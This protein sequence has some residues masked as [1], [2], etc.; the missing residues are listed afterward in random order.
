MLLGVAF[1][2]LGKICLNVR[3]NGKRLF[4]PTVEFSHRFDRFFAQRFAVRARGIRLRRAMRNFGVYDDERG[5]LRIRFGASN[6]LGNRFR[7]LTVGNLLHRPA[8]GFETLTDVFGKREV[9]AA[10]NRNLVAVIEQNQ[11]AEA[12]VSRE[13]SGFRSDAFHEAA[14]AGERVGVVIDNRESFAIELGR[15][16]RFRHRHADRGCDALPQ[17]AGRGFH[18]VRMA[19]LRMS[20]RFAA[21]LTEAL[22]F[23]HRQAVAKEVQQRI[24]QHGSMSRGKH[25]AVSARPVRVLRVVLHLLPKRKRHR[26]GTDRKTRMSA[27]RLLNRFRREEANVGNRLLFN[28]FHES[29]F[30]SRNQI[31]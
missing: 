31:W 14:V 9:R 10:L 18:A 4:V 25:K 19:E 6:R 11:L 2:Q 3:R 21:P 16:T 12:K 26:R 28:R 13:R 5:V 8:V 15:Q 30:L 24:F 23:F 7:I 29:G 20:R 27:V 1:L 17:R 22:E